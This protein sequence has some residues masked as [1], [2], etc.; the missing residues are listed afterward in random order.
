MRS[1][2]DACRLPSLSVGSANAP[3]ALVWETTNVSDGFA[4]RY[5]AWPGDTAEQL[6]DVVLKRID[7]ADAILGVVV[8]ESGAPVARAMIHAIGASSGRVNSAD[9]EGRFR[10]LR[11][12]KNAPDKV[13]LWVT[14]DGYEAVS[15]NEEFA[16]GRE[17]VRI[18]MR[19]NPSQRPCR[20]SRAFLFI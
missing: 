10:V 20:L 9:A 7:V 18:V 16:W 14:H 15:G 3:P 2:F 1:T 17:D 11:P 8:D 13:Q 6:V 12:E 19:K 4:V 5:P